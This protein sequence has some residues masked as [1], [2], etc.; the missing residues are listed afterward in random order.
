M[1]KLIPIYTWNKS[2]LK[3]NRRSDRLSKQP[4]FQGVL[5]LVCVVIAMLLANLPFTREAYH[6]ILETNL[7]LHISSPDG[8]DILFPRDMTV[9]KFI[10]DILMSS[11]FLPW[12]LKSRGKSP[13]ESSQ[14][15]R[16]P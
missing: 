3:F 9:E 16:R 15:S 2:V 1:A 5:L 13:A 7:Q 8:T 10:N 14:R 4:W 12:G 11:S 6:N